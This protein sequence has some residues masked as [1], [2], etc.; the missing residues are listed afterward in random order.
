MLKPGAGICRICY[1][2]KRGS[3]E[4]MKVSDLHN[5]LQ[6]NENFR[7]KQLANIGVS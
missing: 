4:N 1:Y 6:E 7:D 5:N 2:L 3:L